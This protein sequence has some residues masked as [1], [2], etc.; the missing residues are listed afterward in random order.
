MNLPILPLERDDA[1]AEGGAPTA[2]PL[3]AVR[4][5]C[6]TA[7]PYWIFAHPTPKLDCN[8]IDMFYFADWLFHGLCRQRGL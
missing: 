2:P 5:S 3:Y 4:A 1:S 6:L 8:S 7:L